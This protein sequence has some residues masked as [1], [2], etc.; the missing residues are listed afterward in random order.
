MKQ[1]SHPA[2]IGIVALTMAPPAF[3]QQSTSDVDTFMRGV[4]EHRDDNWKH[5]KEFAFDESES[6]D[7]R[8]GT[9]RTIWGFTRE[10]AWSPSGDGTFVRSPIGVNGVGLSEA[11][12]RTAER[13]WIRRRAVTDQQQKHAELE[14][15]KGGLVINPY[16]IADIAINDQT[17]LRAIERTFQPGSIDTAYLTHLTFDHGTY[18]FVGR[19]T[20]M[21]RDVYRV[22]YYPRQFFSN[23][24]TAT[25]PPT[26]GVVPW[27][28]EKMDKTSLVTF[29]VDPLQY[30]I[31]RYEFANHDFGFMPGRTYARLDDLRVS[32]RMR[33]ASPQVWLPDAMDVRVAMTTASGTVDAQYQVRYHHFRQVNAPGR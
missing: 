12:R 18:A 15:G 5:V 23:P 9:G 16:T 19:E 1:R 26:E 29:W 4:L 13:E 30:Q 10:F 31:L 24:D 20:M 14:F 6:F 7:A 27:M 8:T 22:E 3:S 25:R 33:E 11:E 28:E 2:L 17:V 32:L 21:G